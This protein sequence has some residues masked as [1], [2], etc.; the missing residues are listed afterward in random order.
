MI[1]CIVLSNILFEGTTYSRG[2][3]VKLPDDVYTR[4]RDL[5]C[6]ETVA[7]RDARSNVETERRALDAKADEA[8]KQA[9][10]KALADAKAER[11]L[12]AEAKAQADADAGDD[13]GEGHAVIRPRKP[14]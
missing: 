10:G 9:R 11:E 14:R 12:E 13:K 4:F 8:A 1:D 2:E 3:T 6:V 7:E 5:G